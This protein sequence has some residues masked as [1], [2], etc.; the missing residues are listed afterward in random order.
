M[1]LIA[2]YIDGG[3]VDVFLTHGTFGDSG[4]L[5]QVRQSEEQGARDLKRKPIATQE[6]VTGG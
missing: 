3:H 5:D 2:R 1:P 6:T 4:L